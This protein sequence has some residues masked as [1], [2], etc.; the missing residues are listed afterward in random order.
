M[1]C[2][3]DKSDNLYV[4]TTKCKKYYKNIPFVQPTL[5]SNGVIGGDSFAVASQSQHEANE[6]WHAFRNAYDGTVYF[7]SGKTLSQN[8]YIYNP[9]PIKVNK[10]IVQNRGIDGS[11][12]VDWRVYYKDEYGD[13]VGSGWAQC[14]SGTTSNHALGASNDLVIHDGVGFHKYWC[15]QAVSCT[16]GNNDY[17]AASRITLDAQE[18]VE[19]TAGDYDRDEYVVNPLGVKLK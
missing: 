9:N 5:S 8:L 16:G 1:Y 18:I 3:T 7:L 12:L 19:G 4:V 17:W 14:A 15:I 6:P 2:I 10:F 11:C 13:T